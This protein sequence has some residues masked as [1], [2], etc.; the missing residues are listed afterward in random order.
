[1]NIIP[2]D[3]LGVPVLSI[4]IALSRL[5]TRVSDA[6]AAPLV[7]LVMGD[8]TRLGFRKLAM[9]PLA[10]IRTTARVPLID[11]GTIRLIREGRIEV[12]GDVREI[13]ASGVTFDDGRLLSFDAIVVATGY[14]PRID[15]FLETRDDVVGMRR[16]AASDG[17]GIGK[18]LY[19]CG[20]T[21]SPTGMLREIGMEAQ[22]I[23]EDIGRRRR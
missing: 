17:T 10:Q 6:L 22:G 4:G 1:V 23:A 21:V 14:R 8:I 19:F 15:A 18:G 13:S 12:L 2:R 20:F 5:P 9:G 7:R 16:Q 3:I 11:V